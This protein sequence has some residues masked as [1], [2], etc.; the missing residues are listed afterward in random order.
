RASPGDI[1]EVKALLDADRA[2]IE[3]PTDLD[4][5][6]IRVRTIIQRVVDAT[7]KLKLDLAMNAQIRGAAVRRLLSSRV[8]RL[9]TRAGLDTDVLYRWIQVHLQDPEPHVRQEIMRT[10]SEALYDLVRVALVDP[11]AVADA[12]PQ[13]SQQSVSRWARLVGLVAHYLYTHE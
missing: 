13:P 6:A 9:W 3:A 5:A 10:L 2:S 1:D 4:E 8:L 7:G 12:F 11:S